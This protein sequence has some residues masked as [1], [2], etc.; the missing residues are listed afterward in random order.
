MKIHKRTVIGVEVTAYNDSNVDWVISSVE[1]GELRFER[2]HFTLNEAIEFYIKL[3]AE[4]NEIYIIGID[5]D[6]EQ[7]TITS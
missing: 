7:W 4:L 2:K 3:Y 1:Y 5:Q 6:M